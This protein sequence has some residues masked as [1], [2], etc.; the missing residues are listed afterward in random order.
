MSGLKFLSYNAKLPF[1]NNKKVV[2]IN[3]SGASYYYYYNT[4]PLECLQ[5]SFHHLLQIAF[6][7]GGQL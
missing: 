6:Q 7:D 2:K 1:A 3:K 4:L 5:T